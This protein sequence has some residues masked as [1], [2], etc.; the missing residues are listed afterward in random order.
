MLL[1]LLLLL[2]QLLLLLLLLLQLLV[3][4]CVVAYLMV[5]VVV[6]V[7]KVVASS[8]MLDGCIDDAPATI[9]VDA[10]VPAMWRMVGQAFDFERINDVLKKNKSVISSSTL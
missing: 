8:I 6:V 1:L 9:S 7:V 10:E 5:V 3:L 2:L 4:L